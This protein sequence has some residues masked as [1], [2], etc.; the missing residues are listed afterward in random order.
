MSH[1]YYFRVLFST[2]LVSILALVAGLWFMANQTSNQP[3][4]VLGTNIGITAS[5]SGC[6]LDLDFLPEKRIPATGNA[7]TQAN[8]QVFDLSSSKVADF[9]VTTDQN[10]QSTTNLCDIGIYTQ[11]GIY[12]FY[13]QA[14]S[15]LRKVFRSIPSFQK[16][17]TTL[18]LRDD[19]KLLAGEVSPI[20]DNT[21]NSLDLSVLISKYGDTS[22]KYDLN[23][24]GQ[25]NSLD[26]SNAIYNLM[27]SG[28]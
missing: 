1:G 20:Y 23:R 24:D 10:G 12:D 7:S 15:H 26:I 13:V 25:V 11:N 14:E 3:T 6:L 27:R 19:G 5:V 17:A 18:D 16:V 9:D 28:D 4:Q 2:A 8:I 21:I 22:N